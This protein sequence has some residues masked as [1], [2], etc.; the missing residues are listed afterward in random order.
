MRNDD[1][2]TNAMQLLEEEAAA[3]DVAMWSAA[4]V[5]KLLL[6]VCPM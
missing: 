6:A 1:V 3:V 2:P 4:V 5:A